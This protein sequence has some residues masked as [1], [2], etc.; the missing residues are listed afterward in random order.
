MEELMRWGTRGA[1][2]EGMRQGVDLHLDELYR[3]LV[4]TATEYHW[5]AVAPSLT[6]AQEVG[7]GIDNELEANAAAMTVEGAAPDALA[8]AVR[9]VIE[10]MRQKGEL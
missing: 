7:R 4:E 3:Y 1:M 5:G 9:R 8:A 10:D 6:L 2:I